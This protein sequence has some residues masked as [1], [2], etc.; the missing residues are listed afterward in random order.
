MVARQHGV[1]SRNAA[2]SSG[3]SAARPS[4]GDAGSRTAASRPPRRVCRRPAGAE[5]PRPLD[6][7]GAR[8]R[9]GRRPQ[10]RK[11][12]RALGQSSRHGWERS[13]VSVPAAAVAPLRRD[14]RA[15]APS[16]R[17][18]QTMATHEL[19][20]PSR[21]WLGRSS[22]SPRLPRPKRSSKEPSTRLTDSTGFDPDELRD[23]PRPAPRPTGRR[24]SARRSSTARPS[25]SPT[26]SSSVA[27]SRSCGRPASRRR[28]PRRYVNGYRVDFFWPS[29]GLVVETDG[30][31][32][33]PDARPAGERPAPRPDARR[34]R[35]DAASFHAAPR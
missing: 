19:R 11:R 20:C 24:W 31:T 10:P 2:R 32:L 9:P 27:F 15:P 22:T 23:G 33:S 26:P 34:R 29:L 28:S 8:L 7:R 16:G 21:P 18:V 25:S 1:V 4:S 30:L 17:D 3:A 14:P 5:P 12:G 13:D 6:G 35:P